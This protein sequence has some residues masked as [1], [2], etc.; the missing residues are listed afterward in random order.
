MIYIYLANPEYKPLATSIQIKPLHE[1]ILLCYYYTICL[2]I[3]TMPLDLYY[4][5]HTNYKLIA[6]AMSMLTKPLAMSMLTKPLAMSML[7]KPLAMSMLTKP[8]AMS[9]LTK[10]LAISMLTKPL[11]MSM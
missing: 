6:I 8:L 1:A 11:A 10:P 5:E 3:I 7:T 2:A 9:M 4:Y